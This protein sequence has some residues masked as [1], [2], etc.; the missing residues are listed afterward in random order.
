MTKRKDTWDDESVSD[1]SLPNDR[2]EDLVEE[3]EVS[4][5]IEQDGEIVSEQT[6]DIESRWQAHQKKIGGR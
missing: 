3:E 6:L 4:I 2:G 5:T 1:E